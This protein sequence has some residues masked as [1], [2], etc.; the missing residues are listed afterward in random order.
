MS[1]LTEEQFI[2]KF[3]KLFSKEIP[4]NLRVVY[5]MHQMRLFI[6]RKGFDFIDENYSPGGTSWHGV[7]TPVNESS[8][9]EGNVVESVAGYLEVPLEAVI[10]GNY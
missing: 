4:Q 5:D 6:I 1:K 9:K 8:G 2:K 3:N 10:E 7:L